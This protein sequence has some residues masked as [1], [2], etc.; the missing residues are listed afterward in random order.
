MP[1]DTNAN[2]AIGKSAR[3]QS[4]PKSIYIIGCVSMLNDF[5][6]EMVTPLIPILL[7]TVLVSGPVL[8][9]MVEGCANAIACFVQLW[10]GRF[11]DA[12]GG[13]R[14][15]FVVGGYLLSNLLRPLIVLASAGWHVVLIRSLDRVGKGLRNA[16]RDALITD[17]APA[18]LRGRAFGIHRAFDNLGA[19]GG[20]LIGALVILLFSAGLRDVV[21]LSV[22]PGL[23]CVALFAF[24]VREPVKLAAPATPILRLAWRDVPIPMRGYL[25]TV[26]LFTFS[27]TAEL[28]IVLRAHEL[29]A[30]IA[31]A[32]FLWAALNFVKIFA[33]V[34]GGMLADRFGRMALLV[35][36]WA[37][38]SAAMLGFCF[39]DT[40]SEL[41]LA[42]LFFGFAMSV[43]EGVER[44]VIGEHAR[45]E[46]RGTLFGW[47]YALMGIASIPAGLLLGWLWQSAGAATAY[48]FAA[49][50]GLLATLILKFVV[51]PGVLRH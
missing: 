13:R 50:I 15:P 24:A 44:A 34:G 27:R 19:V 40:L 16:P 18:V 45:S 22:V 37:L 26:M 32:L 35:P 30:S 2:A 43:S 49:G 46:Q 20:A 29:G 31:H 25:L 42:T 21:L 8:L 9:G 12:R 38:H 4:I 10:S 7:A 51:A 33:N 17:L 41:W 1:N 48:A 36:G 39:V 3:S 47:Y 28:F 5:A 23:L 6:T 11:S 14:K